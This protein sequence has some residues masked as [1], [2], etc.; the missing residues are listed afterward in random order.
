MKYAEYYLQK[1]QSEINDISFQK[2]DT[3]K[4]KECLN[5]FMNTID[6]VE[7]SKDKKSYVS[8]RNIKLYN[9]L[10]TQYY[11]F[12]TNRLIE[13]PKDEE[14]QKFNN[15]GD[16]AKAYLIAYDKMLNTMVKRPKNT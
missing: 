11:F 5:R 8:S 4:K 12:N 14:N 9:E 10:F 7:K 16:A 1:Y 15:K 2:L 3:I 6:A 13:K